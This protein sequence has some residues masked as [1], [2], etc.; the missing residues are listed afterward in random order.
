[1]DEEKKPECSRLLLLALLLLL[2]PACARRVPDASP[3][4]LHTQE[5]DPLELPLAALVHL[6]DARAESVLRRYL[7]EGPTQPELPCV[8]PTLAPVVV[9]VLEAPDVTPPVL[10]RGAELL[11]TVTR[12]LSPRVR[13]ILRRELARPTLWRSTD[14]S[15]QEPLPRTC[16]VVE[17]ACMLYAGSIAQVV[18]GAVREDVYPAELMEALERD[19]ERL[20]PLILYFLARTRSPELDAWRAR[21]LESPIPDCRQHALRYIRTPPPQAR[22]VIQA[23]LE[24][25]APWERAAA[26]PLLARFG[27]DLAV[28]PLL[29]ALDDPHA[30][31][32]AAAAE[33]LGTLKQ[34][35]SAALPRLVLSPRVEG[36]Y[37][38]TWVAEKGRRIILEH[39]GVGPNPLHVLE[40]HGK[41]LVFHGLMHRSITGDVG[42]VTQTPQGGWMM[43]AFAPLFGYPG[44]YALDSRGDL[45]VAVLDGT[46]LESLGADTEDLMRTGTMP[47][48]Y[49]EAF[50]AACGPVVRITPDGQVFDVE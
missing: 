35:A 47:R 16:Q 4:R 37:A 2:G 1:M 50:G 8:G 24:R 43:T 38:E 23:L 19:D 48:S 40:F 22:E 41:R 3:A 36:V 13:A 31:V 15:C 34:K 30:G 49:S 25:G 44:G 21:L 17:D 39:W 14:P 28:G 32:Q 5:K 11:C 46:F 12:K 26:A 42:A 18:S 7:Q 9:E 29:R 10:T 20:T 6:D 45:V 27:D 33:A